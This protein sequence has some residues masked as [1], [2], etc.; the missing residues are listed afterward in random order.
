MS[1][2][3]RNEATPRRSTINLR[4]VRSEDLPRR[5]SPRWGG[6]VSRRWPSKTMKDF[7]GKP[8]DGEWWA[9]DEPDHRYKGVLLLDERHHGTLTLRG[10]EDHLAALMD[11]HPRTFFGRFEIQHTYEVSLFNVGL[12]RGPSRTYPKEPNRETS[13]EL[14]TNNIL[15]GCHI[16]SEERRFLNGALLN[17][18]GLEEWCDATGFSG[19]FHPGEL[20]GESV[21][22][23]F[24]ATA[25]PHYE[26]G[27]G[28]LIRFLSQYRGPVTFDGRKALTLTERN[29]IELVF[30]DAIS[31]SEL[32]AEIAIWQSFITFGLR[33][34]SYIDEAK[35]L[36]H[37]GGDHFTAFGLVVPGRRHEPAPSQRDPRTALF[38]QSKLGA[39]IPA[40]VKAWRERQDD[41][42]IAVLLFTGAAYQDAVYVHTNLLTYL[43][44]LEILHRESFKA[45]RF[46]DPDAR[47]A[48]IKALRAAVPATLGETLQREIVEQLWFIGNLTLLDRLRHLFSLY[49]KSLSPLFRRGEADMVELKDVR[50]FLTHYGEQKSFA[51]DFLWSRRIFFLKEKARLFLEICLLGAIGMSDDQILELLEQFEPFVNWRMETTMEA[52]NEALPQADKPKKT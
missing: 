22:V 33:R 5:G 44:V 43:Q 34:P 13:A 3:S 1:G 49:P 18:T 39:S 45:D 35:V 25:S 21:D 48:T 14:Y 10:S 4:G 15:I 31:I 40:Y 42:E 52:A 2:S 36:I 17:L 41:I 46:P 27:K 50:N 38:N 11:P 19:K 9:V 23:S 8:L 7:I 6:W 24:K 30:A 32:L 29:T 51:K 26:L 28:R 47:K 37:S 12:T 16:E 20:A